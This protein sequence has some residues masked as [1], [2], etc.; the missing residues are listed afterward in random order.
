MRC[1]IFLAVGLPVGIVFGLTGNFV[2]WYCR[3]RNLRWT[4]LLCK[5]IPLSDREKLELQAYYDDE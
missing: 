4:W 3:K 5:P 1:L 2:V